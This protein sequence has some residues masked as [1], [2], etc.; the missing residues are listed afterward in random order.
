LLGCSISGCPDPLIQSEIDEYG[1]LRSP[2]EDAR[3][4]QVDASIAESLI[5]TTEEIPLVAVKQFSKS[6]LVRVGCET[7]HAKTEVHPIQL[8]YLPS[9]VVEDLRNTNWTEVRRNVEAQFSVLNG[10]PVRRGLR[11][12][13]PFGD[14]RFGKCHVACKQ[15]VGSVTRRRCEDMGPVT[16]SDTVGSVEAQWAGPERRGAA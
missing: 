4:I 14:L 15:L 7:L 11:G 13:C 3:I 2:I 8:L 1:A 12:E 5:K 10:N 9:F 6:T 16:V